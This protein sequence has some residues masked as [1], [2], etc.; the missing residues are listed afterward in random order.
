MQFPVA[1][2]SIHSRSLSLGIT[3]PVPILKA[4]NSFVRASSRAPAREIPSAA[5]IFHSV[6][7]K[8]K[9]G[10]DIDKFEITCYY[11]KYIKRRLWDEKNFIICS[12]AF[13]DALHDPGGVRGGR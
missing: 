8:Q 7:K 9:Y 1:V 3:M 10:Y 4:G 6:R 13:L 2:W 11:D 12:C 5:A